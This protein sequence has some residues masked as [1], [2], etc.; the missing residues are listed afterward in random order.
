MPGST[1]QYRNDQLVDILSTDFIRRNDPSFFVS[2]LRADAVATAVSIQVSAPYTRIAAYNLWAVIDVGT[3]ECEVRRVTAISG[4]NRTYAINALAYNHD[5]G[6]PV[7]FITTP[8]LNAMWF[9]ANPNLADNSIP[10]QRMVDQCFP[11]NANGYVPL[12][13]YLYATGMILQENTGI[14]GDRWSRLDNGGTWLEYSGS[15]NAIT[16]DGSVSAVALRRNISIRDMSIKCTH[17]SS[18]YGIWADYMTYFELSGIYVWNAKNDGIYMENCHHGTIRSCRLRGN[19]NAGL[20]IN[21]KN[22]AGDNTFSGQMLIEDIQSESSNYGVYVN[23]PYNTL[24]QLTFEK[25]HFMSNTY[26]ALLTSANVQAV[27]F[28]NCHFEANTTAGLYT[29]TDV[30]EGPVVD[31]CFFNYLTASAWGID[32][33]GKRME[34]RHSKFVDQSGSYA[35][36]GGVALGGS[37]SRVSECTF[38]NLTQS[39]LF[40]SGSTNLFIDRNTWENQSGARV[41]DSGAGNVTWEGEVVVTS[42][43]FD[44]SGAT[45]TH[46]EFMAPKELWLYKAEMHYTQATSADAGII[47]E[48]GISTDTDRLISFTTETSKAVYDVTEI[49]PIAKYIN[50]GQKIVTRNVGGKTGTGEG[51]M[52]L[53]FLPYNIA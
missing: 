3:I 23:A 30:E 17:V 22:D 13:K 8:T 31:N 43:N 40:R 41:V 45:S 51:F 18:S 16:I 42:P 11:L 21:V 48:A 53:R 47:V 4:G 39:L 50:K 9:G 52:V 36:A 7:L 10:F 12:G 29:H 20:S 38:R 24:A 6:D 46:F 1:V 33:H 27:S 2:Y 35:S 14:F 49:T 44:F 25:C 34:V 19:A 15:G 26:G 32:D 37:E 28:V 5:L